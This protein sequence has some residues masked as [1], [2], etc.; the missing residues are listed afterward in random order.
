MKLFLSIG[1]L[2]VLTM[3]SC[4]ISTIEDFVVGDN[5][6]TDNTGIVMLDTFTIKSATVRL[7]SIVS[8]SSDRFLVGSNYNDFSG[9]KSTNS[10]MQINF[11]DEINY[12]EIVFDSINLI[13]Y[14]DTYY[15]GDTTVTQ[16]FTV[17]QLEEELE[18]AEDGYLYSTTQFKYN[19][20]PLGS[21]R[22]QPRPFSH[23]SLSIRLSDAWGNKLTKMIMQK[24]DTIIYGSIFSSF[25]YGL[26]IKCQPEVKGAVVGFR[27]TDSSNDDEDKVETKPEIRLYYHLSSNP[28]NLTGLYY[29]FSFNGDKMYFN[30]ITDFKGTSLIENISESNNEL[31]SDL[32]NHQSLIQ[33]GVQIFSKYTFPYIDKLRLSTGNPAFIGATLTLYP[34][35]GTYDKDRLPDSL[36]VYNVNNKNILTSQ[37]TL[38]GSTSNMAFARLHVTEDIEQT[39]YYS[40]DVGQFIDSELKNELETHQSLVIG[41]NSTTSKKTADHMILGGPKSGKYA[42][43]LN[44]YYFHN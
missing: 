12:T 13:L 8:N 31:S 5:F 16:T 21:I 15:F 44:V 23:K 19:K 35:K 27:T 32:T 4:T 43:E 7:D 42:P 22:L 3:V 30:Q 40:I 41:F 11:D 39:V 36:V 29:K 2:L 14:Y 25:L 33:S 37:L 10:I 38:Q 17:H 18:P 6:I 26:M 24:N 20:T 1:F 9:Y 28:E 34:V